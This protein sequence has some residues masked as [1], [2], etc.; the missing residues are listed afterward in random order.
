MLT[1]EQLMKYGDDVEYRTHVGGI[2]TLLVGLI[3]FLMGAQFASCMW[4]PPP[5]PPHEEVWTGGREP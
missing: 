2:L 5:P 3:M 1:G 4:L